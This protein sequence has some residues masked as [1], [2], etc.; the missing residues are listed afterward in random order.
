MFL[1]YEVNLLIFYFDLNKFNI[2][3]IDIKIIYNA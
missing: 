3:K 1:R 2:L